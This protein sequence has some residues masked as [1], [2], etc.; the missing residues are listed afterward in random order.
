MTPLFFQSWA[1]FAPEPRHYD[2]KMFYRCQDSRGEKLQWKD[3][4]G[5]LI[6][7]HHKNRF[8]FYGKLILIYKRMYRNL[9]SQKEKTSK[10]LNCDKK[11]GDQ[12][13]LAGLKKQVFELAAYKQLN[14]FVSHLCAKE[15]QG[16]QHEFKIIKVFVRN[17]SKRHDLQSKPK[18]QFDSFQGV[19]DL[20][21]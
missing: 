18:V 2:L 5:E 7:A 17:F 21:L 14:K 10:K 9:I 20:T 3:P 4:L 12:V 11:T 1:L 19:R 16:N 15:T 6:K 13:C 8:T